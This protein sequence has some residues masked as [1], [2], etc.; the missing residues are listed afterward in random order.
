[1]FTDTAVLIAAAIDRQ[2]V[3]LARRLLVAD[4]LAAKRLVRLD[5]TIVSTE[6]SLYF[7]CRQGDQD[8]I[9]IRSF[10]NWLHEVQRPPQE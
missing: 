10:R 2:G 8:R 7:V 9:P 1:M 4:D 3:A 5:E 6:R